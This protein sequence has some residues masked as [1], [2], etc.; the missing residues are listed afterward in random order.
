[1]FNGMFYASNLEINHGDF[2]AQKG[3]KSAVITRRM[4][5]NKI[6]QL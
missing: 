1:M 2:I 4:R 5:K 6:L 3:D